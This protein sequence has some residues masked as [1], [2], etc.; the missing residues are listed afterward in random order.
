MSVE[1]LTDFGLKWTILGHSERR[2][3]LSETDGIVARKTKAALAG[4]MSVILCCGET[5]EER[6]AGRVR[7][8]GVCDLC[9]MPRLF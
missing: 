7:S 4:G 9:V 3:L 2:A 1:L 8:G 6:E 5:L